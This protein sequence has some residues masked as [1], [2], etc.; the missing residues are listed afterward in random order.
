MPSAIREATLPATS[1]R[2]PR[3]ATSS[4]PPVARRKTLQLLLVFVTLVLIINALIGERGLMETLRAR[5]RHTDVVVAIERLR[6][7]NAR[8]REHVARL[9]FDPS[10]IEALARQ[11]LGLIKPGEVL[12]I[13]KD[14]KPAAKSGQFTR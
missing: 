4:V 11:E 1:R 9:R 3:L 12:F 5:Q 14:A 6:A 2:K 10:T 8:L 7:E 13:I